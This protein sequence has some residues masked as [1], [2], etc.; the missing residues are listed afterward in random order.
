MAVFLSYS[1]R[2]NS[3]GEGTDLNLLT[4]C[5]SDCQC[6]SD[7]DPVCGS[8]SVI[9]YSACYAGCLVEESSDDSSSKVRKF[10]N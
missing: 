4:W 3:V 1:L 10:D 7:F 6:S 9:Y 2:S 5:N 8:D